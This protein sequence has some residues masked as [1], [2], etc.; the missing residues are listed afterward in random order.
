MR[1]PAAMMGAAV[2]QD[3]STG[4]SMSGT[5]KDLV[6]KFLP[7]V[8]TEDGTVEWL[9]REYKSSKAYLE[10]V[11]ERSRPDYERTMLMVADVVTKKGDRIG[12]WFVDDLSR[13]EAAE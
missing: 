13:R 10:K 11:A 9:F 3:L 12:D 2:V 6:R 1:S 7:P 8:Y 4:F 5:R